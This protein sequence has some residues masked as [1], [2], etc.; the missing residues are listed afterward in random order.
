MQDVTVAPNTRATI[1]VDQQPG[2]AATDV[3]A[4]IASLNGVPI[5]VERA[6][7]S[8]AAGHVR[9]RPRQRRRDQPVARSGSSPRA[10]PAPSSTRSCCWPTRTP[11]R[12]NVDG[13]VPAAVG[14]DRQP[15][16]TCCRRTAGR[17]ST[18][19]SRTPSSPRRRCR[20]RLAPP[21]A[22]RSWPSDRCGGRTARPW[23]EAH[24][25]AGATT[26]GT[27]WAVADGEVGLLPDDTATFLL[28]A[29]TVG[30]RRR[31]SASRCCSRP[32]RRSARTSRCRPTPGST[33][34]C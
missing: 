20:S 5:I 6:M 3:S 17:R 23:T 8:S 34:R 33:C 10:R 30:L 12:P 24:N 26:T 4:V 21:T 16:P 27:K 28:V 2:L 14:R 7:Y 22:C 15:Q 32:A 18:S 29:N 31:R 13:D 25:A 9:G 11:R 19:R 1:H